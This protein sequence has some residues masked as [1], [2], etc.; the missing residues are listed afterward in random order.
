MFADPRASWRVIDIFPI[1]EQSV[2]CTITS[3]LCVLVYV[4]VSRELSQN[5][6]SL[7]V[8][9]ACES[10]QSIDNSDSS[11]APRSDNAFLRRNWAPMSRCRDRAVLTDVKDKWM[12]GNGSGLPL[13]MSTPV[14]ITFQVSPRPFLSPRA[15]MTKRNTVLSFRGGLG[16][17]LGKSF[18]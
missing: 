16:L 2:T 5:R 8:R 12:C 6:S 3:N 10:P 9:K 1:T 11:S 18:F 7:P 14:R 15:L 17:S 13:S 4:H